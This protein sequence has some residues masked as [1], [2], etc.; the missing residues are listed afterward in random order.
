MKNIRAIIRKSG[1]VALASAMVLSSSGVMTYA[2]TSDV[3]NTIS[4]IEQSYGIDSAKYAQDITDT[5]AANANT[6][7]TTTDIMADVTDTTGITTTKQNEQ[8]EI[9]AETEYTTPELSADVY[10]GTDEPQA[11]TVSSGKWGTCNWNI[12]DGVLTI[13]G[14]VASGSVKGDS[15]YMVSP[16][17][18]YKRSIKKVVIEDTITF[19]NNAS[20]AHLFDGWIFLVEIDGLDK[21]D[22]SNVTDMSYMFFESCYLATLDVSKFNTGNVTDMSYMFGG[23]SRYGYLTGMER[24]TTIDVSNFDTSNVTD[25]SYMFGGCRALT[26]I[27]VSNF[28]TSKVT[29]MSG[30]F[31]G[32]SALTTIDVS[33]F[34]TSKVTYMS[35]M[36]SG[37]N[38]LTTIDVSNFDTG[39]VT[40]MGSMFYGCSS[41]TTIDLS[42]FDTSNVTNMYRMFI[43]CNSLTTI[44]VSNFDTSNVTNMCDMFEGC[45]SLTTIDVSNFDTGNVKDMLSMFKGCSALTTIDV[46]NFNTSNVA[47]M[48]YMFSGCNS[49]TTIDVSNFDTGNV[50]DMWDMFKGCS[51]LTTID[52]SNFDTSNVTGMDYLFSGCESLTTIDVS[53]FNTS[54]VTYMGGMF[55]G[56]SSLT[57]IDVS[58]FDTSNVKSMKYMFS[59][60]ESLTTIDVSNFDTSNVTHMGGMF[61]GCKSLTTINVSNF[62]TGNVTEMGCMFYGCS[63]LTTIDLSKLDL[64]NSDIR[65]YHTN[66]SGE[67]VT[68]MANYLSGESGSLKKIIMPSAL[69]KEENIKTIL[70]D[71][72]TIASSWT[73]KTA[74]KVYAEKPD[75]LIAGHTYVVTGSEY[76]K[77]ELSINATK[78]E[79]GNKITFTA[80]AN[81]GDGK[82]TYKFL[83]YNKTTNSWAKLQDFSDKNTFTW[84]KG[85]AGDRYFYVDVKD[86]TGKTVRSAALN[87]NT[88]GNTKPLTVSAAKTENGNKITFT[89]NANGGNG[90]YTYKFLVYNKTTN[91][92]A[93]LQDFSDKNT[94][95]WTKGNAGDRYFYV[96]VKDSTGKTVRSAALNVNTAGTVSKPTSS[97]TAST[98][99]VNVG[100]KVTLTAKAGAGSGKYTY[101]FL[102]YN[103]STNQWA[104]LQDFSANSTFTWTAG[105]AGNRQF[106]V[107]VKDSNGN[108]TRSKVVNVA[109]DKAQSVNKLT[110]KATASTTAN[111][112]GENVTFTA[113]ANGGTGKY[114]YKFLVYNKTTNQWAKL[115]DFGVASK[116]TWTAGSAAER[117]FFVDVKDSNGTVVRSSVMNVKT[118]K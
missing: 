8:T 74:N 108:V 115:Q 109:V 92:W 25:M 19:E 44:D 20:L 106:Y 68:V 39:N 2:A 31:S 71:M 70:N 94:F 1:S 67:Q 55:E 110:V 89:A 101:K 38:S 113:A 75:T 46:S 47:R 52:V 53:N 49:L 69:G 76:D 114:T 65:S 112:V 78:K 50:T 43:S 9:D 45:E 57:T 73:D 111:K 36:F 91:S 27:D 51:S 16:W 12:N 59:G 15:G 10:E 100:G 85:N 26:T 79:N 6:I 24:V 60:C 42:N 32:C 90:K 35:S 117:Q 77:T 58:N 30:M 81:G 103:P 62:D 5:A 18:S 3:Q 95:T 80:N 86:S 21:F 4:A 102:I 14:G 34:D 17:D 84:T 48:V 72:Y 13:S 64:T 97:L 93:K 22:T 63:S 41:L 82:Y 56:C 66:S 99:K 107:D 104:K 11:D 105:S 88:A 116:L 29:Y 28:D 54:N 37:C 40:E 118:T 98:E 87:V 33:N 7:P 83:V 96:D 61:D 23:R